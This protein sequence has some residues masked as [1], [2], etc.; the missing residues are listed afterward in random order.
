[1]HF[2]CRFHYGKFQQ[3]NVNFMNFMVISYFL[4]QK[5]FPFDTNNLRGYSF[6]CIFEYTMVGYDYFLDASTLTLG[7]GAYMLI[8]SSVKEI[9]RILRSIGDKVRKDPKQLSELNIL[10]GEYIHAHAAIKQLSIIRSFLSI[11]FNRKN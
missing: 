7:I 8:I 11:P 5:R 1:M 10:F 6:A 2:N 3:E 9:L 4:L